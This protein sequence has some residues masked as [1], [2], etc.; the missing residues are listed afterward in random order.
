MSELKA[1]IGIMLMLGVT[2]KNNIDV[3]EIWSF[4][5]VHHL[6]YANACMPRKRFQFISSKLTFDD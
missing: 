4:E 1:F 5:S 2:R 3:G 6:D